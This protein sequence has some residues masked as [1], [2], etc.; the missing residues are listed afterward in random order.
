MTLAAS[1]SLEEA[2]E[3][4]RA[5]DP[6]MARLI[7]H[8]GPCTMRPVGD[9]F[10]ALIRSI[11]YQQLAGPAAA[12]IQ[13]RLFA[14]YGSDDAPPSPEELLGTT[15]E[16]FR[17]A[18][19]SRQKSSYL[20]DLALQTVEGRLDFAALPD[21]SDEEVATR[22]IAVKGVGEWTAHMFLMFQLRRPDI[23]PIGDLGVLRGMRLA[24][25]LEST[26]TAAE[27]RNIGAPWV[28]YRSVGSWYMWRVA[29]GVNAAW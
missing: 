4:L 23:L 28:P 17:S 1:F 5:A 3:H 2:S 9:P 22:L 12:A 18:G 20:H 29:E 6:I 13:R 21:L 15:D 19:V 10:A 7:D 27:A 26:P 11:M 14:L 24:Y 16:Q 8:F 25:G